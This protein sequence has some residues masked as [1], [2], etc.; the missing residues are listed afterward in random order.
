MFG[1][2]KQRTT[3]MKYYLHGS[4]FVSNTAT[5]EEAFVCLKSFYPANNK[6][7]GNSAFR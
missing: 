5:M 4:S 7:L 6:A 3:N 2:R 1:L